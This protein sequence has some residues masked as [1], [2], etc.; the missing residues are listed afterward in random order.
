MKKILF[1]ERTFEVLVHAVYW[2]F[3][4]VPRAD[5]H[6]SYASWRYREKHLIEYYLEHSDEILESAPLALLS[7]QQRSEICLFQSRCSSR[8]TPKYLMLELELSLWQSKIMFISPIIS[9]CWQF[10]VPEIRNGKEYYSFLKF[11]NGKFLLS[12]IEMC[13]I[14]S[15][16]RPLK[17]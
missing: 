8:K 11:W 17:V 10:D 13:E 7:L 15:S 2:Q 5:M 12:L 6:I 3:Q 4:I 16:G 14:S 1:S 9:N